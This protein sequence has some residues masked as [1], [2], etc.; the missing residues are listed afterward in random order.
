MLSFSKEEYKKFKYIQNIKDSPW[1]IEKK[2]LEK[3]IKYIDYIKWI[4]WLKMIA[5]W[6]SVAMNSANSD[7]DID[8][9]VV[10]QPKRMWFVRILIT[11][12]FQ[13]LLVRKTKDKHK[14][15]FCLSFFCTTNNLNFENISIGNDIYL[16]F[17]IVYLKPILDSWNTYERFIKKNSKWCNFD[18]FKNIIEDNKK[19][20]IFED[21]EDKVNIWKCSSP[22]DKGRQ[23]GFLKYFQSFINLIDAFL[24]FIFLPKTK[25]TYKKLWTPFW[26][27]INE[28][29]LKFHN[30]DM[31]EKIRNEIIK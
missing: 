4:P 2:L 20:I 25:R 21:W 17:W 27:I 12:I 16:F 18:K 31:R 15:R 26:V 29:M 10:T 14:A 23:W 8:L 19:Y 30:D 1:K 24:K 5:I 6:N 9:F 11:L 7:S 3:T 28:N 22:L 13:I